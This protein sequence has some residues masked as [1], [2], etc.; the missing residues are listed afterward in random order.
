MAGLPA[1]TDREFAESKRPASPPP[2]LN[3]Q[4]NFGIA[5]WILT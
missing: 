2:K 4:M 1:V 3:I 5:K